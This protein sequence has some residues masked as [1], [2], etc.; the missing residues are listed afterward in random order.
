M[1]A[2]IPEDCRTFREFYPDPELRKKV[3]YAFAHQFLPSYV[4]QNPFAFFSYLWN[5]DLPGGRTDPNRFLHSRWS[6]IFEGRLNLPVPQG[7]SFKVGA[8]F[9]RVTDLNMTI[10]ELDGRASAL[11]Q[12]PTPE[13]SPLAYFVCVVLMA[14]ASQA[15]S[16]SRDVQ[17]RVFTLEAVFKADDTKCESG[18]I[19]EWTKGG[20]HTNYGIAVPA[21]GTAFL[22][23]VESLLKSQNL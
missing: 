1:S 22:R 13:Q 12:M 9:R 16:W 20:S 10:Q 11:I 14:P 4:Q 8:G 17:A 21:D 23:A 15:S 3:H 18:L 19:C 6:V 2:N 5:D 7:D